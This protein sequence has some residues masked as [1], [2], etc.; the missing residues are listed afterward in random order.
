MSQSK[1]SFDPQVAVIEPPRCSK[2]NCPTIFTGIR[3]GPPG[4]YLR[5]LECP[6]CGYTERIADEIKTPASPHVCSNT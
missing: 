6:L 3:P 1:T 5:I 2:C 4:F